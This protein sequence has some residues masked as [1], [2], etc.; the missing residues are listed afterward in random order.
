MKKILVT[1]FILTLQNQAFSINSLGFSQRLTWWASIFEDYLERHMDMPNTFLV[2]SQYEEIQSVTL[3]KI[4]ETTTL[5]NDLNILIVVDFEFSG[6]KH[7]SKNFYT[8]NVPPNTCL[9]ID[10][11]I[12]I[13]KK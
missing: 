3:T 12:L 8:Y 5:I 4:C 10:Y 9:L 2:F 7:W 13:D 6:S 11:Q 1:L